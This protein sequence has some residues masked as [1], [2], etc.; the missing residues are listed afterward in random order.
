MKKVFSECVVASSTPSRSLSPSLSAQLIPRWGLGSRDCGVST[1]LQDLYGIS[2]AFPIRS[3]DHSLSVR[4]IPSGAFKGWCAVRTLQMYF[5]N[6]LLN[7]LNRVQID[8]NVDII[9][10]FINVFH[11]D[12]ARITTFPAWESARILQLHTLCNRRILPSSRVWYFG[13]C[14]IHQQQGDV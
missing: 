7:C 9:T 13:D 6:R 12:Y 11:C 4:L 5:S 8:F 10:E 2:I 1:H 3:L 14:C